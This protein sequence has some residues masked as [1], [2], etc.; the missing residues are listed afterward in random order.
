VAKMVE[1]KRRRAIAQARLRAKLTLIHR[2]EEIVERL[3]QEAE[4][5]LRALGD[6][7]RS[8][9]LMERLLARTRFLFQYRLLLLD[10]PWNQGFLVHGCTRS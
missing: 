6:T 4:S 1:E 10:Y 7:G 5:R 3:W 2:R 9:H 8:S